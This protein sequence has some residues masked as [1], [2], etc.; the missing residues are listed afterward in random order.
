MV[1][2]ACVAA[3]GALLVVGQSGCTRASRGNND[4][5]P[6]EQ[7][8][9][10][11]VDVVLAREGELR[12]ELEYTGT[13]RATREVGLRAQTEGRLLSLAADVGDR[14]RRGQVLARLDDDLL[15]S[16]LN[17][18]EAEL[19]SRQSEVAAA[20]TQVGAAQTQVEQARLNLGQQ[21]ADAARYEFLARE[22]AGARQI[23]EQTRTAAR[24]AAQVLRSQG[25]Q[26]GNLQAGVRAA[27]AR[28]SAQRAVIAQARERLSYAVLRSPIDG[29]VTAKLSEEG[30]L[31]QPGGEVLRV[32]DFGVVQVDVQV[33]EL[34]LG[35]VSLR[36]AVRVRLDAQGG[37]EFA[38]RVD[39]ISPQADPLTRLVPVTITLPNPDNRIGG[40]LLARVR[41]GRAAQQRIVLPDTAFQSAR[42]PGGGRG[43]AGGG[44][45]PPSAGA[46]R[47]GGGIRVE[48][49]RASTT[50]GRGEE[51]TET[52]F[53]LVGEGRPV[54]EGNR[55][56]RGDNPQAPRV[57]ARVYTVE[58]RQ[59]RV[60]ARAD[61][62]A[63]ILDGLRVGE[64]VVSRGVGPLRAGAEVRPSVLSAEALRGPGAQQGRESAS[65]GTAAGTRAGSGG[66]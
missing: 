31:V 63:E 38:G 55:E 16:A 24:T 41:F 36:Q 13:T 66:Q 19:A 6:G 22:G 7:G 28:V 54:E 23:A 3:A 27:Q 49:A 34:E 64:R 15:Q 47:E 5:R 61:G 45:A 8:G 11:A 12:P 25:Q 21:R 1:L 40:G 29:F 4:P 20:Q 39:R 26:V 48:E 10:V 58:P 51:T 35:R 62:Q 14:V 60:G 33:S 18:A 30:N 50:D 2:R 59:V 44:G 43:Q 9:P 57:P 52:V 56:R 17:Q 37:Q 46:E 65:P 42:G 32:G 53:A